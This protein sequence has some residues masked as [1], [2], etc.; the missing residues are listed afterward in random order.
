ML[1]I[2]ARPCTV[3]T[4]APVPL[5]DPTLAFAAGGHGPE[6]AVAVAGAETGSGG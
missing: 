5:L 4:P 1:H 6:V 3:G 2:L